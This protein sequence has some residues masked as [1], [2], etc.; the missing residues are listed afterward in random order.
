VNWS[1]PNVE[2]ERL[3]AEDIPIFNWVLYGTT[4]AP[5][6]A[7]QKSEFAGIRNEANNITTLSGWATLDL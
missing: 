2:I 7:D 4:S 1:E 3:T 5:W 6:F